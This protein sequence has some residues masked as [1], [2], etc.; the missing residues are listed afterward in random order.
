MTEGP[1]PE[2]R[3]GSMRFQDENT[4]PRE[5][6]LAERKAR[7]QAEK[8]AAEEQARVDE[9]AARKRKVRKRVM[10]GAGVT[11]G[12]AAV[13]GVGYLISSSGDETARC[14]DEDGVIVDDANCV[15]P[16]ANTG[17][18]SG[19]YYGGGYAYPVFIGTGG[20]QYHYT[21]GGSGNLGQRVSGGTTVVPKDTT[22]VKTYTSGR[23]ISGGSSS[24]SSSSGSGPSLGSSNSGTSTRGGLGSSSGGSSSGG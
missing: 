16:A 15:T 13:V 8:R 1:E 5:P 17:Y 18:S 22:K 9:E 6:T 7:E 20:R 14:T 19:G 21:Y 23:T 3:P 24:A 4:T 11:V 10:I 2:Q 12:L